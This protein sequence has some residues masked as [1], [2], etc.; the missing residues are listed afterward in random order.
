MAS[1]QHGLNSASMLMV[2]ILSFAIFM[3]LLKMGHFYPPPCS[4][5]ISENTT[6][7]ELKAAARVFPKE[8]IYEKTE[9]LLEVCPFELKK[10]PQEATL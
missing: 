5:M 1:L 8:L 4:I 2:E 3:H 9:K 10:V 7:E 6:F